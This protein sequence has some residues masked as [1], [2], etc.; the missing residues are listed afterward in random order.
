MAPKEKDK[1][2]EKCLGCGKTLSNSHCHQCTVC[3]LW[4]HKVCSGISDEFFKALEDQVKNTGMAYWACRPCTAYS[5][6][7]TRKMRAVE[8]KVTE[9]GETV[10][11]VRDNVNEVKSKVSTLE[12]LVK[13]AE[14]KAA[15]AAEKNNDIIF[16][17]LR[18]REARRLNL[19][20]HGIAECNR[21][22]ATGREKQ[23][24]D[25]DQCIKVFQ[26]MGLD[27]DSE[28]IKFCRRVGPVMEGPRPLIIGFYTDMERSMVLRRVS[29][30]ADTN[31][32]DI[33]IAPDLTRRQRKE[34]KDIWAD[35]E[36]RNAARTDEQVQKNLFWAVVGAR[37]EKRLL[38]QPARAEQERQRGGRGRR[39]RP[40]FNPGRGGAATR[41]QTLGARGRG[42]RPNNRLASQV[43]AGG[44]EMEMEDGQEQDAS[45]GPQKRKAAA[46]PE[47]QP[48][49]KR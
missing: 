48:L 41:G 20:L 12:G 24:W 15:T 40:Q 25:K 35:M 43:A 34:E 32:S 37:G 14:E 17:E 4:I 44:D 23:A 39:G 28:V 45:T 22:A 38:L 10:E 16:E 46:G 33:S 6:G 3:G 7:I 30:L 2:K 49:E 19:V 27:Y 18:E 31:F 13:K 29:R 8:T 21:E 5:Q 26:G 11:E 36:A 47:G 1:E 42:S 9:L